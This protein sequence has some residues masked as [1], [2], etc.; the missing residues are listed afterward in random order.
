MQLKIAICDDNDAELSLLTTLVNDW[1]KINGK[2]VFIE[3]FTSSESFL[4]RY[5]DEKDFSI[6]LLDIE[7]GGMNGVALAKTLRHENKEIQ[8]V[9]ITGYPDF[10]AEGYD[11][12]ALHYLLKPAEKEK[13][14]EVLSLAEERITKNRRT[15]IIPANGVQLRFYVDEITFLEAFSHTVTLH[16]ITDTH[17][18]RM[19]I[20]EAEKLLV[21]GF[22]RCHRSYIVNLQ[23]LRKI[24]KTEILLD[25][26]TVLPLSRRLYK[27]ANDAFIAFYMGG[28]TL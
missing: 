20:G 12:Q 22:F 6:L 21:D 2:R 17:E 3:T 13:F 1:A 14:F 28:G 11:V 7:M 26:G 27:Q 24:D 8:I 5:E 25:D 19:T 18:L 15:I 16:T 4:F 10:I 9:F 23:Y